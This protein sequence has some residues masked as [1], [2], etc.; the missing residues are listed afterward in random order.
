MPRRNTQDALFPRGSR[1]AWVGGLSFGAL[2]AAFLGGLATLLNPDLSLLWFMVIAAV[3]VALSLTP[4]TRRVLTGLSSLVAF[5]LLICLV[6]PVLRPLASSLDVTQSPA[7]ADVIVALGAGMRCGA[8]Q[9]ESASLARVVKALELWRAG[10]APSVTL[11]DTDGVWTDCP[12][13]ESAARS[14][15]GRLAP[16]NAPTLEVL[17]GANGTGVR[18][19]RDEAEAVA[20]LARSRGWKRVLIVT[21]PS[22]SRRAQTTFQQLKL[23]AFVVAA[24]EPRFDTDL[25]LP[26]DRLMA[27]PALAREVAGMVKYTL[28]GWL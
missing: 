3:S 24:S 28:F 11:S 25:R 4:V 7:R 17:R 13:V 26:Y 22:H 19:T 21:S 27:L 20:S 12:S 14:L 23:D 8:G 1:P 15:V 18:N 16:G 9:L 2:I 6:T 10:F 5:V